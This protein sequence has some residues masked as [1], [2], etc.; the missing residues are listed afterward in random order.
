[1]MR[2]CQTPTP[3]ARTSFR[4]AYEQRTKQLHDARGALDVAALTVELDQRREETARLRN[5]CE[6]VRVEN[7]AL[8]AS[9]KALTEALEQA[10]ER[11]AASEA[12]ASALQNM[13][14]VRWTAPIRRTV[15]RLR[16]RRG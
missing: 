10:R 14:V 7:Q 2:G 1:M 5:E 8:H 15:H 6:H 16:D 13:K 12:R 3:T 9:T 11:G 4:T